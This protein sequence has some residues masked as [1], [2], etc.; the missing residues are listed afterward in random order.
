M[1]LAAM[2]NTSGPRAAPDGT[3]LG[4]IA[5]AT[6]LLMLPH[7]KWA[8]RLSA[9]LAM[10]TGAGELAHFG[11]G[12]IWWRSGSSLIISPQVAVL[13]ILLGAGAMLLSLEKRAAGAL[14]GSLVTLQ[15]A[16]QMLVH[17]SVV[18]GWAHWPVGIGLPACVALTCLGAWLAWETLEEVRRLVPVISAL[19]LMVV[20]LGLWQNL[21]V[22]E[23]ARVKRLLERRHEISVAMARTALP[24][25][26]LLFGFLSAALVGFAVQM[27]RRA[28][29]RERE[30]RR[31]EEMKA[32]FLANMSHEIRTP[33]NGVLGMTDL[34]LATPM[35]AEQKDYLDTIRYSADTLL[36]ILND[37]LDFSKIEAGKVLIE[38]IGFNPRRELQE[39]LTLMSSRIRQKGLALTVDVTQLPPW[40]EGDPFRFRQVLMN[41]VGNA[42]K[43][44][45]RGL[46]RVEGRGEELD[47][48][49]RQRLRISVS[50]TGI[51]IP[52]ELQHGLF[53]SFTQADTS[54]TRRYGGT[55]LG[56][57][58]SQQ[59]SRLMGGDLGL[60]SRPG[61][62]ST[63]WFTIMVGR[64][65]AEREVPAP[66]FP[67]EPQTDQR[68]LLVEDNEVNRRIALRLLEK[69]GFTVDSV[70][71]GREAV[72]AIATGDY[73][74][75]L[76]DVQMPELDGLE[77]TSEV[78][79]MESAAGR[80][81]L[82]IIAM[83]ANAMNG[84]RERCLAAGMDDYLSKPVSAHAM[85]L[86]VRNWLQ[87]R[88]TALT[89]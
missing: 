41:L 33:M 65:V 31:A 36:T 54:T 44:T 18:G 86:K 8:S 51:G 13:L 78:R 79:K 43:F 69:A 81:R 5:V 25:V 37:I 20:S 42:V 16:F 1:G 49:G 29:Q 30:A 48:E 12:V 7:G 61:M 88:E 82:P 60:E 34:L 64:A 59:L 3:W 17:L 58:I 28:E 63:F 75:A 71:N 11:L 84:D 24:E 50:D 80:R 45:D 76:M 19:T 15:A 6:S 9:M 26:T 46:I 4:L 72:T 39:S 83:T 53:D 87:A 2:T 27:A 67:L 55:G 74:L 52:A 57:A 77:A 32:R 68:L 47:A 40:V 70:T 22:E 85:E 38:R 62:G 14:L 35:T 89:P 23:D 66:S 73:A 10:L 56:L 21:R